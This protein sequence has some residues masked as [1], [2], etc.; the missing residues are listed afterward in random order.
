MMR[1]AISICQ[2][3][4]WHRSDRKP[5]Y[6]YTAFHALFWLDFYLTGREE[7]FAPP[8]PFTLDELDPAGIIPKEPYSKTQMLD[9]LEYINTKSADIFMNLSES[10]LDQICDVGLKDISYFELLID[11]LRHFQHHVGQLNTIL[12][13]EGDSAARWV[14][15]KP[16]SMQ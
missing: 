6:W 7:G 12:R 13:M 8:A 5:L 15:K 10:R 9:Y 3:S 1:E 14:T 11:N 4:I 2:E 16:P